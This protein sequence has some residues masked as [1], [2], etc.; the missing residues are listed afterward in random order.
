ML[1]IDFIEF[2]NSEGFLWGVI[3]VGIIAYFILDYLKPKERPKPT[4][5]GEISKLTEEVR[6]IKERMK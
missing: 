4:I 1:G 2:F 5:T 3:I 6:Q